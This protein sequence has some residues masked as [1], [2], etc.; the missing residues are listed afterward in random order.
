VIHGSVGQIQV[1]VV[2]AP[3]SSCK[4]SLLLKQRERGLLS[5]TIALSRPQQYAA[6][7]STK[8]GE[9]PYYTADLKGTTAAPD[10]T[11]INN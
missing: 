5:L 2:L 11:N 7:P 4:T 3:R 10:R 6:Q 9:W 1:H 8:N